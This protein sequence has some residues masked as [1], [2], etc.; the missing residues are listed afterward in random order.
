MIIHGKKITPCPYIFNFHEAYKYQENSLKKID[1]H[2][3]LNLFNTLLSL[4]KIHIEK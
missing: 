3:H 2:F 4:T 1:Y